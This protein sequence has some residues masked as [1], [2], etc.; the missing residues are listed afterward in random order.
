M[1]NSKMQ[2][3]QSF[4]IETLL[5]N[6][7]I[8]EEFNVLMRAFLRSSVQDGIS[9]LVTGRDAYTMGEQQG[10]TI[11]IFI[12]EYLEEYCTFEVIAGPNLSTMI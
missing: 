1:S 8:I 12:D 3:C 6:A 2:R 4:R 11:D 7:L 9:Y 5:L 10:C